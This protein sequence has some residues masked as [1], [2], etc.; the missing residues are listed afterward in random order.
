MG[1]FMH[2]GA[3]ISVPWNS[4][5]L[6]TNVD[7]HPV[8]HV[9]NLV[10]NVNNLET[11]VKG[12]CNAIGLQD[13]SHELSKYNH[14]EQTLTGQHQCTHCKKTFKTQ[15]FKR[16]QVSC[17]RHSDIKKE[18]EAFALEHEQDQRRACWQAYMGI[19]RFP[20]AG[21]SQSQSVNN[22]PSISRDEELIV[23]QDHPLDFDPLDD[24]DF[25]DAIDNGPVTAVLIYDGSDALL[26]HQDSYPPSDSVKEMKMR[27][28]TDKNDD[29]TTPVTKDVSYM[30]SILSAREMKKAKSK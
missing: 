23:P 7:I 16:H 17:K 22:V 12:H 20:S 28:P 5:W 14:S 9:D 8:I 3:C 1:N 30:V 19:D 25:E 15:G 27:S 10:D 21:P 13:W 18:Q 2:N 4:T 6:S 11:C 29:P 26:Y 24:A